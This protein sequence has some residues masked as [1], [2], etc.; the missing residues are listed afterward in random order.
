M[1][2][3]ASEAK[4]KSADGEIDITDV[5]GEESTKKAE[6]EGALCHCVPQLT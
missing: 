2:A 6:E 3:A 4:G 5:D 1:S